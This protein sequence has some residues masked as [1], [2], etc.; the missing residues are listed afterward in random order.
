MK[1]ILF[2]LGLLFW[3][4]FAYDIENDRDFLTWILLLT[5]GMLFMFSYL[6]HKQEK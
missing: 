1:Y 5:S 3:F 4:V 6:T 2:V